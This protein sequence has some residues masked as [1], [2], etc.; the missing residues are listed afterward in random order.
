MAAGFAG[1]F[2]FDQ[3]GDGY[4][5]LVDGG[6]SSRPIVDMGAYESQGPPIGFPAGDY[7]HDGNVD[8][9]DYTV[10]RDTLGQMAPTGGQRRQLRHEPEQ[11]R[12]RRLHCLEDQ[13]R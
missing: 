11:D 1:P 8:A 2:F 4:A 5:R 9:A 10:W 7:N 6:G 13:L 3:R 12:R